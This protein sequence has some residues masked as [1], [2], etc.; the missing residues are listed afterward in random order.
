MKIFDPIDRI[1]GDKAD[2]MEKI[3][4]HEIDPPDR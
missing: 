4:G 2:F 3:V 1:C